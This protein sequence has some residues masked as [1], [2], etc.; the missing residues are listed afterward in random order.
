MTPKRRDPDRSHEVATFASVEQSV[1]YYI[2]T[3][4]TH[5]AYEGLREVRALTRLQSADITGVQLAAGLVRYSERGQA[6]VDEIQSM[7][8]SNELGRFNSVNSV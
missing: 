7:I 4:N 5:R 2:R 8:R 1:R 6:Y 3:L